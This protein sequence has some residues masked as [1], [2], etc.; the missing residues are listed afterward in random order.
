[1]RNARL[2]PNTIKGTLSFGNYKGKCL[3]HIPTDYLIWICESFKGKYKARHA[4][5][6]PFCPPIDDFLLARSE[7]ERRG[8]DTKGVT[9][10]RD[11]GK[12]EYKKEKE[13][14]WE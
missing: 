12:K 1:M 14:E 13:N 11:Y 7:L 4:G 3:Y 5:E 10:T 8:Y 6:K 9:P 2:S